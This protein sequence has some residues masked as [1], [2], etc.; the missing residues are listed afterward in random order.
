MTTTERIAQSIAPIIAEALR[1]YREQCTNLQRDLAFSRSANDELRE[2]IDDLNRQLDEA[3]K[4]NARLILQQMNQP[5]PVVEEQGWCVVGD[6]TNRGNHIVYQDFTSNSV[7]WSRDGGMVFFTEQAA[8]NV[9][10]FV[11]IFEKKFTTPNVLNIRVIP[12]VEAMMLL[13]K[14]QTSAIEAKRG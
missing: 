9:M 6:N 4:E 2:T 1:E 12:V 14:E 5:A 3:H 11:A 8:K 10:D 7:T 13:A